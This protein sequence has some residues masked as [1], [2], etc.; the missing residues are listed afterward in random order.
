MSPI[1]LNFRCGFY[2]RA[3]GIFVETEA[4]YI[5]KCHNEVGMAEKQLCM[6]VSDELNSDPGS[7]KILAA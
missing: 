5:S 6:W 1:K 2:L 7:A 4:F 3:L